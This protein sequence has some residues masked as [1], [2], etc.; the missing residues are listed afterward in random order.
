MHMHM[1]SLWVLSY[2]MCDVR[3]PHT[4][5]CTPAAPPVRFHRPFR[6]ARSMRTGRNA[7]APARMAATTSFPGF[8]STVAALAIFNT[9]LQGSEDALLAERERLVLRHMQSVGP[10]PTDFDPERLRLCETMLLEAAACESFA[11]VRALPTFAAF[12]ASFTV[13]TRLVR[14]EDLK[15][16]TGYL[17]SVARGASEAAAE[18]RAT[19]LA[20]DEVGGSWLR[21]GGAGRGTEPTPV[22]RGGCSHTIE[23]ADPRE[24]HYYSNRT[25]G[26]A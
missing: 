13:P 25:C 15:A 20:L 23:R 5:Q 18:E 4:P 2:T 17:A 16:L 11:A 24:G 22:P 9:H 19:R 10:P 21:E 6:R 7:A 14:L 8:A 12:E 1:F 3:A 26:V